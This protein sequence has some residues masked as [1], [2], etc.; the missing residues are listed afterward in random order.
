VS[1]LYQATIVHHD[2][3]PQHHGP[4]AGA[5]HEATI[6]NPLCGDVVTMRLVIVDGV[7]ADAAFE[8]RG[9]ALARA[10]ASMATCHTI[11]QTTADAVALAAAIESLVTAA[12]GSPIPAGLGELEALAGARA[13]KSRRTCACLAFR[14]VVAA[15]RG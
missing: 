14:A 2:R 13:F 4:L 15:I 12:P 5:T 3:E 8:S 11:G 7:I 6:D 10:G 9:C 1:T